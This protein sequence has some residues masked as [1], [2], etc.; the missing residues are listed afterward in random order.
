MYL[1]SI[2]CDGALMCN[3][4]MQLETHLNTLLTVGQGINERA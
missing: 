3:K 2:P 1:D 4:Q